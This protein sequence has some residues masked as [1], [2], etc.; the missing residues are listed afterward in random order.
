VRQLTLG[1]TVAK[2][3]MSGLASLLALFLVD[4]GAQWNNQE[5]RPHLR[6]M[7]GFYKNI[8]CPALHSPSPRL[9]DWEPLAR[10]R[11]RR[12]RQRVFPDLFLIYTAATK[13]FTGVEKNGEEFSKIAHGVNLYISAASMSM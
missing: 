12:I 2:Q 7:D 5:A 3:L 4:Q 10:G 11:G 13:V 1:Y 8:T 9:I 6:L